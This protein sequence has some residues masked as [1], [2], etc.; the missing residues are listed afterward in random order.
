MWWSDKCKVTRTLTYTNTHKL[1]LMRTMTT[2]SILAS[3]TLATLSVGCGKYDDGPDFSLRSRNERIA[4]TWNVE[5]ATKGGSDVTSFFTQYELK[6]SKDGEA[7]LS[8]NYALGDLT[9]EFATSGSWELVNKDED[10]KLDFENNDADETYEILRL[11]EDE[12][13][14]REKDSDL[15]LQL[16]PS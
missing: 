8:A 5:N 10:L 16:K 2:A 4:N 12:L 3:I 6:M 14:L 13:W 1:G 15:E 11:K 7:T 9:F